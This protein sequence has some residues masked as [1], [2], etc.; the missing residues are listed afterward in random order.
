MVTFYIG[1][2]A[3]EVTLHIGS[4]ADYV[5]L[6]YLSLKLADEYHRNYFSNTQRVS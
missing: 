2:G 3:E 1:G 4:D 6:S 5:I